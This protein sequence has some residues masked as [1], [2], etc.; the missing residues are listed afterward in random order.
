MK[1]VVRRATELLT[2]KFG[3]DSTAVFSA[4]GR[5]NLI[6]EH[7]D[8]NDGF[9]LPIAIAQRT[10]VATALRDDALVVASSEGRDDVVTADLTSLNPAAMAG[11]AGYVLGVV[12]ALGKQGI[13]LG[14][15]P[16]VSLAIASDVPAGAGLSSSAAVECSV[17]VALNDLWNL[18]LPPH[19]LASVGQRAENEVVGANTGVMDQMVS[20]LGA[21]GNALFLDCRSSEVDHIP[22]DLSSAGLALVVMDT[23]VRH[24]NATSAYGD[25]RTSCEEAALAMGVSALRDVDS[26][27]LERHEGSLDEETYRRARHIVSE[28]DRVLKASVAL[29]ARD[30]K[31]VGELFRSSHISMRDD[32][33]ISSPELDL[34][35]E[36]AEES[37]ALGARMTGGGFG[38]SAIAIISADRLGELESRLVE[39]FSQKNWPVPQP[40]VVDASE[41]ARKHHQL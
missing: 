19:V 38:G 35:V 2:K 26:E 22:C 17:A 1:P 40:L 28:N 14:S 37:G 24:S 12:W 23:H 21:A 29:R 31:R 41:G 15:M 20:M 33:E 9:V 3:V 30:F 4:P 7:T 34:A 11:W 5:V 27:E 13:D 18:G 32:Y 10:V 16:G 25:R 8:Y 39:R 36:C 6:G